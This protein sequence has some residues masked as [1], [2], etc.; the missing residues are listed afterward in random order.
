M[1]PTTREK[2]TDEAPDFFYAPIP[3]NRQCRCGWCLEDGREEMCACTDATGCK[4]IKLVADKA[5]RR[6]GND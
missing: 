2:V 5:T 3:G 1:I 4:G 6:K